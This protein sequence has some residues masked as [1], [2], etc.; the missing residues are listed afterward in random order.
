MFLGVGLPNGVLGLGGGTPTTSPKICFGAKFTPTPT[1]KIHL[2][3]KFAPKTLS[4]PKHQSS[5]FR[6]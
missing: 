6:L 2:G 1:P 5:L 3:A 4:I